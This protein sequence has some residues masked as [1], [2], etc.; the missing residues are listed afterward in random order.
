MATENYITVGIPQNA[1][2]EMNTRVLMAIQE[3]YPDMDLMLGDSPNNKYTAL[4]IKLPDAQVARD[5]SDGRDITSV[6]IM[7]EV[8]RIIAEVTAE[9]S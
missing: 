8:Q 6:A 9:P 3:K 7:R 4:K 2:P 1:D 5:A